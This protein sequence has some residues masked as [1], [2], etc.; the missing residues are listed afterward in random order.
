MHDVRSSILYSFLDRYLNLA[1]GIASTV[2]LARLL[3]PGETG[4]FSIA[5]GLVNIAQELRNFGTG[6]YIL[7][8]RELTDRKI[9]SALGLSLSIATAMGAGF[10]LAAESIAAFYANPA[11]AAIIRVLCFNFIV[12]AFAA[13]SGAQLLRD[14]R[15]RE[16]MFISVATILVRATTSIALAARGYGAISLAWGTLAGMVVTAAGNGLVL[17]PRGLI[18]PRFRDWRTLIHFGLL[19][20]GGGLLSSLAD[21]APDLVIGRLVSLE[22]AGLF[23]RGNGLITLFRTALTSAVDGVIGSSLAMLHR[24]RQDVR[25]PLLR[26]F[27][28]LSAVGWPALCVLGLLAQ[29]IIVLMFGRNWIGAVGVAKILC[30]GAALSLIGNVCRIYLVSTGAMRANF[31]I[32]AISVPVFVAGIAAGSLVSLEAAAAG[33]AATG[34]MITLF[35][36]E[37]LR[38]RIGL[39]WASIG[40]A[41]LPS[42]AITAATAL[43]PLAVIATVGVTGEVLWPPTLMAVFGA[44][45]AWLAAIHLLRHPLRREVALAGAWLTRRLA[46]AA[47]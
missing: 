36:L 9:A 44:A 15:F 16:S 32:Q 21:R 8:E 24:D 23:S 46:R 40:R 41:L 34:G 14:M 4:L 47:R 39:G 7:Q 35:S 30:A 6:P 45:L 26:V 20:S 19:S 43:P 3:T 18:R 11:L 27:G 42:L 10:Y 25:E 17:G 29:P 1:I 2:I 12:V 38:R 22:G 31:L 5:Y 37:V 33:A 13:I 28:T